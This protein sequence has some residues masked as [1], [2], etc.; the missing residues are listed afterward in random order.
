MEKVLSAGPE[1]FVPPTSRVLELNPNHAVFS[2]LAAA[3]ENDDTEKIG[4]YATILYNQA[5]L[6]EGLP[7]DDPLAY[8]QAVSELMA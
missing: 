5:L 4:R 8:A 1:G 7:V 3:Q 2:A 6:I